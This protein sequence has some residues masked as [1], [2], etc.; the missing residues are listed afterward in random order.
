MGIG[1]VRRTHRI[2]H[3]PV[4]DTRVSIRLR[5]TLAYVGLFAVALTVLDFGLYYVVNTALINSID[6]ELDLGAQVIQESVTKSSTEPQIMDDGNTIVEPDAIKNFAT[7]NLLAIV[8]SPDGTIRSRSLNLIRQPGLARRLTL[9]TDTILYAAAGNRLRVTTDIGVARLRVLVVPLTYVNVLTQTVQVGGVLQLVRPIGETERALRFFLY[10]LAFGGV[11]VMIVAAQGGAWLTRAVF[12]PI[13]VIA[14]TAQSIVSAADLRR[15]VPVPT[16]QDE[17][18]LLTVTV[19]DLLERIER[20][21]EAQRRFLADA[22]HELRTPLAAMKG[23]IEILHRGAMRD[24]ELL[25]ESLDDMQRET[26]RLIRLVNDLLMLARN[27]AAAEMRFEVVDMA[28]LLLETMRDLKSLAGNITLR[29]DVQQ[30]VM[31]NGD[32]DRL[33]Q[34]ILNICINALQH[35]ADDGSV[36]C[37]LTSHNRM[38]MVTIQDTGVG[39]SSEDLPYV[40]DRF[41]RAD[42]SRTRAYVGS[43]AGLGLAIVK[44]IVE[45]HNGK[46]AV[47]STLGVG[48][49][50]TIEI[51][52]LHDVAFGDDD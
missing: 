35:T 24:P 48:T 19:N 22:S 18:Q 44:Y 32:R 49:T 21:F 25:N 10:A 27:E 43:G 11:A 41:F 30:V 16:V 28:T 20:L 47:A 45:S 1:G 26:E 13:D 8:Y 9:D 14:R 37:R 12:R 7:T 31:V 3:V 17:L 40:F 15:R 52:S 50:F 42:R 34:A 6:N 38:A 33:K 4:G 46:V 51:P 5:L 39:I 29:L 23:N 2:I 36:V